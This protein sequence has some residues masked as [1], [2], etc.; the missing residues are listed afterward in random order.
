MRAVL[1][2]ICGPARSELE[3]RAAGILREAG[4]DGFAFHS[5]PEQLQADHRRQ[6]EV[7]DDGWT[8]RRFTWAEVVDDPAGFVR[9]V[10]ALIG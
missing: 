4:V 9:A 1:E 2:A 6:R 3:R 7:M 8:V 5:S 10:L